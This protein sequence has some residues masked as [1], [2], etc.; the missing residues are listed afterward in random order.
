M[1]RIDLNNEPPRKLWLTQHRSWSRAQRRTVARQ[2]GRRMARGSNQ[3]HRRQNQPSP[4]LEPPPLPENR[5]EPPGPDS[6][7]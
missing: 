1:P 2:M 7:T 4:A 3:P 6:R 5:S